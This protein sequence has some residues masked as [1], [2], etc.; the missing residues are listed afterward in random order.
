MKKAKSNKGEII[1]RTIPVLKEDAKIV[2]K[3]TSSKVRVHMDSTEA[4]YVD[5]V[6]LRDEH[7]DVNEVMIDK[8][9]N[10][11]PQITE[12]DGLII[13]PVV[14]E[15]EVVVKK[16]I[17]VKEIHVRKVVTHKEKQVRYTV[18]EEKVQI[19]RE[20]GNN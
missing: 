10:E 5:N 15:V 1:P 8:E 9:V 20:K 12:K 13:I 14:K 19:D 18:R 4:I 7:I 11:F 17:L 6:V 3:V 16:I 2:K